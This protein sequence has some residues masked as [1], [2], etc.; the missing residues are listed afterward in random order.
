MGRDNQTKGGQDNQQNL[1]L[2]SKTFLTG[3]KVMLLKKQTN[4]QKT[5]LYSAHFS[6][7]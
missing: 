2:R 3:N 6:E 4:K 1:L 5:L 7:P